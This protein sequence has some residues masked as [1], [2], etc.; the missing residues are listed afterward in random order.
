ML[1]R[2]RHRPTKVIEYRLLVL[3]QPVMTAV[4]D[5][6]EE[7][8]GYLINQLAT[9]RRQALGAFEQARPVYERALVIRE[10]I[11]GLEH[12]ETATS[13]NNLGSLLTTQGDFNAARPL[14]ERALTLREKVLGVEHPLTAETLNSFAA[15]LRAQGDFDAAL[16]LYERSLAIRE[17][18]FGLDHPHIA[19]TLNN[20]AV[21]HQVQGN[22]DA[23]R[24]L[25][26]R[27][28]KIR[29]MAL[30]QYQPACWKKDE[31]QGPA[32]DAPAGLR[33]WPRNWCTRPTEIRSA[34]RESMD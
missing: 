29:E 11:F 9:F 34:E 17:K 10:R 16:P 24:R 20:L 19:S 5:G 28:L 14:L 7:L 15:L 25:F 8:A 2:S 33:C 31:Y 3:E 23:A 27:A 21:L 22:L 6:V 26:E 30:G 32:A 18:A 4:Q 12:P 13:I 1:N